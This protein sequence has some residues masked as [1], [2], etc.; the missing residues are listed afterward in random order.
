MAMIY[1]VSLNLLNSP[2]LQPFVTWNTNRFGILC[3]RIYL[4]LQFFIFSVSDSIHDLNNKK[5]L[6]KILLLSATLGIL[7]LG[8]VCG[9]I[10]MKVKAKR[11]ALNGNKESL[12]LP[13]FDFTTIAAATSNFSDANTIGEGGFGPVYKVRYVQ[14]CS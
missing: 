1:Q 14:S 2:I 4:V 6:V 10:I 12:E 13:L 5:R 11:R 8:T 3:F 7:T 9:C